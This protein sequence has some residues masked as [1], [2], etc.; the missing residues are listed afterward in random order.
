[1]SAAVHGLVALGTLAVSHG[2]G[3]S[4]AAA[5]QTAS[6]VSVTSLLLQLVIG[7]GVV[8]GIIALVTRLLRGKAGMAMGAR[9]QGALTVLHRQS[10]GKGSAV[11]I[12]RA[13]G[14]VYL[15]GV[16]QQSVRRID[17][18]DARDLDPAL[19]EQVAAAAS[20]PQ[21]DGGNGFATAFPTTKQRPTTTWTSTIE[22]L[23]EL[24][25]RRG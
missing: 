15:L 2:S 24:T 20:D 5:G 8:L 16:T 1:V 6:T 19:G 3:S 10:L 25:V 22:Q 17:E 12:V 4:G 18:L 23:R 7:L 11:A 21:F 9:R 14:H 13:A